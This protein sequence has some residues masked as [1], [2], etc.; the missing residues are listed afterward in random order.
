[1]C[2]AYIVMSAAVITVTVIMNWLLFMVSEKGATGKAVLHQEEQEQQE[3]KQ[4]K[5]QEQKK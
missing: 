4:E 2:M 5:Q 1:M 3:M